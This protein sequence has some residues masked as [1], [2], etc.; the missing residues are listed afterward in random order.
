MAHNKPKR[1]PPTFKLA[2]PRFN[3]FVSVVAIVGALAVLIGG[4]FM[5]MSVWANPIPPCYSIPNNVRVISIDA[6]VAHVELEDGTLTRLQLREY[7]CV[8]DNSD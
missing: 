1:T 3:V 7:P 4:V 2:S 6:H 5:F 8:A